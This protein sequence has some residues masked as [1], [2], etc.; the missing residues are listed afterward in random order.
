MN[1]RSEAAPFTTKRFK[2]T[3]ENPPNSG[4]R[5]IAA[6]RMLTSGVQAGETLSLSE[7]PCS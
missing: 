1:P 7:D 5:R 4:I 6:K 3:I 2:F